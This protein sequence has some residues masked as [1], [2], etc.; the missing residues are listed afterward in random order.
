MFSTI[1]QV[2]GSSETAR[3]KS[4][5]WLIG[6]IEAQGYLSVARKSHNIE[7][8]SFSVFCPLRDTQVLYYI[9]GLLGY[10]HVKLSTIG[11][12]YVTNRDALINILPLEHSEGGSRLVGL[13][14]GEG[15]FLVSLKHNPNIQK[16][17]DVSF[18]IIISQIEETVLK[19]FFDK[20]GGGIRKNEKD[21]LL[22]W[23]IKEKGGL[24]QAVRLFKK[25]SLRTKKKVDFLKWC[26]V[27]ELINYKLRLRYSPNHGE[28]FGQE[29]FQ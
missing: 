15:V 24:N 18:S 12:F 16:K 13:V 2:L 27:L 8:L 9:K 23:E 28:S 11:R 20:L 14:D 21:G 29:T 3:G 17:K 22:I 5:Q 4:W 26:R 1:T 10:G 19:P 6:F 25:H 7:Y